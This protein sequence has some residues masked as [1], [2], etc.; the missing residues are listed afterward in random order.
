MSPFTKITILAIASLLISSLSLADPYRVTIYTSNTDNAG[1]DSNI[2]IQFFGKRDQHRTKTPKYV[3]D[4]VGNSFERNRWDTD[5]LNI[6]NLG[7]L[8]TIKLS[9]DSSGKNPGWLPKTVYITNLETGSRSD[10][11]V[12]QWL[13]G[14]G[15]PRELTLKS[16]LRPII[17]VARQCGRNDATPAAK[18]FLLSVRGEPEIRARRHTDDRPVHRTSTT[19]YF[20]SV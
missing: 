2:G 16:S 14:K 8:Y 10:F 12:N 11:G 15:N 13:G 9:S 1:T 3:L 19:I 7:Q 6:Q 4:P 20:S 18:R 5:V 17:G